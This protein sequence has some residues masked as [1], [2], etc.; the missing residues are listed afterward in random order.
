MRVSFD[1]D[2]TLV[3]RSIDIPMERG[4]LPGSFHV[5][6]GKSLRQGT[7]SLFG[8][9]RRRGIDIWIYTTSV[10]TP[11]HIRRWLMLYGLK[12]DGLSGLLRSGWHE[13]YHPIR[14][15]RRDYGS[16]KTRH[17]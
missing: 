9:L 5:W 13:R 3:C 17:H 4:F 6:F 11:F 12:V 14:S 7:R 16:P 1:I 15:R 8:E 10:R 2:E